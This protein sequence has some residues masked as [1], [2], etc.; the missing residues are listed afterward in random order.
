MR[1]RRGGGG[2]DLGGYPLVD[3]NRE[4]VAGLGEYGYTGTL[5]D[6]WRQPLRYSCLVLAAGICNSYE[7]TSPGSDGKFE[8]APGEYTAGEFP[9]LSYQHD[10]VLRDGTMIRRPEGAR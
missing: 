1:T 9:K 10:L 2:A 3:A 7:L 4:L 8:R 6:G 5:Q